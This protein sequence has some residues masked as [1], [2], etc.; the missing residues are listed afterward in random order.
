M[1]LSPTLTREARRDMDF[2]LKGTSADAAGPSSSENSVTALRNQ[3][4]PWISPGHSVRQT[5]CIF[6]FGRAARFFMIWPAQSTQLRRKKRDPAVQHSERL[7]R[8]RI[9]K[10][11]DADYSDCAP[12]D[13]D[14]PHVSLILEPQ[15]DVTM[16]PL[17][18]HHHKMFVRMR[19]R[20]RKIEN[21]RR[22]QE[23]GRQKENPEQA[24][25][26]QNNK[27]RS[28]SPPSSL[29]T[30]VP[31]LADIITQSGRFQLQSLQTKMQKALRAR[32]LGRKDHPSGG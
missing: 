8:L 29:P 6:K 21:Q 22:P 31:E 26:I 15:E 2:Q 30:S 12:M 32:G 20:K 9:A 10:N 19:R 17:Q 24:T 16:T 13:V 18:V 23:R 27:K 25:I 28:E 14:D 7:R 11:Y 4:P 1:N 5:Y 3:A